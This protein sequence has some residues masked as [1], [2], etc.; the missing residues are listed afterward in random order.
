MKKN[1]FKSD[2]FSVRELSA[3]VWNIPRKPWR[4][5]AIVVLE[6]RRASILAKLI[7]C[8]QKITDAKRRLAEYRLRRK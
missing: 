3:C 6:K 5:A 7:L 4:I 1:V 2:A 8:N